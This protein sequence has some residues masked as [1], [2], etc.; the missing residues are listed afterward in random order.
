MGMVRRAMPVAV[1]L[2]AVC[3][4]TAVLWYLKVAR[5]GLHHPVFFYLLPIALLAILYGSLPA[6]ICIFAATICSAYFLYD[7][8]YSFHVSN[9]LEIG[10]LICFVVLALIGVKC[11]RELLRP[12]ANVAGSNI[13][14]RQN[15]NWPAAAIRTRTPADPIP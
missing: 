1:S 8:V 5:D 10:D 12:P 11:T 15:L 3:L 4:V 6:I 14:L 13:A 7:P 9:S 2:A